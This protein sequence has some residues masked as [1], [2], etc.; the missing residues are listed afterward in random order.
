[1]NDW[2]TII[3]DWLYPPTCLL[4]GEDGQHNR[5]LCQACE[6]ALPRNN[7]ACARCGIALPGTGIDICGICMKNPPAFDTTQAIFQYQDGIRF[8]IH[9]L[10]F[11]AN[12]A[13]ARLLGQLMT[14]TLQII[15]AKPDCLIPVPLHPARYRQRGFNQSLEIARTLS[16]QLSIP[17]AFD[18]CVRIRKTQSQA[19]LHANERRANLKGAFACKARLS[20]KRVAIIDDVV[21]TG[22]T[23]NELAGVLRKAGAE[24]VQVWAVARA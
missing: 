10:K 23:V 4:C 9:H 15:G 16:K 6:N 2:S 24:Q 12:Y 13:C 1:M 17:L 18:N 7:P 8:L 3:Q 5:D 22:T 14:D 19:E 21:T 20:C 11:H